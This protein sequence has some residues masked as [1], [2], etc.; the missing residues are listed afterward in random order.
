M[1][2]DFHL[3]Y[4]PIRVIDNNTPIT[5]RQPLLMIERVQAWIDFKMWPVRGRKGCVRPILDTI[6]YT[7]HSMTLM[8]ALRY[9]P[10][11]VGPL[12]ATLY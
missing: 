5:P 7:D 1:G 12:P 9:R 6:D 8:I 10:H 11:L 2:G 3:E 4:Y